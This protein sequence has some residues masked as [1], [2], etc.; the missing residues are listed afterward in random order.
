[1]RCSRLQLCRAPF[2]GFLVVHWRFVLSEEEMGAV[3]FWVCPGTVYLLELLLTSV[4]IALL[5]H[6][7]WTL[8]SVCDKFPLQFG[9]CFIHAQERCHLSSSVLL[10]CVCVCVRE[11]ERVCS[12]ALVR[13]IAFSRQSL[14]VLLMRLCSN[15]SDPPQGLQP[16]LW[17]LCSQMLEPLHYLHGLL[18]RLY[19]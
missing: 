10:I 6:L 4:H 13:L 5:L 14:H 18:V 16:L 19:S 7:L 8:T 9:E 3:R 15:M 1:V 17:R 12:Q 2:P 11:R